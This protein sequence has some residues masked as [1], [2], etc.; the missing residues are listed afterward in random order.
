VLLDAHQDDATRAFCGEG[1]PGWALQA[2][3]SKAEQFPFPIPLPIERDPTTGL[4]LISSC[5]KYPFFLWLGTM[6]LNREWG[7]F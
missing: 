6:E 5:L 3:V 4:P 1:F 2:N 7:V